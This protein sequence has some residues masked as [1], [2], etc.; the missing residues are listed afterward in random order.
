MPPPATRGGH[1]TFFKYSS[2]VLQKKYSSGHHGTP[3]DD[4][5]F[6]RTTWDSSGWLGF[7]RKTWILYITLKST[8]F[9][10]SGV[11]IIKYHQHF[12]FVQNL[13]KIICI[14][15]SWHFKSTIFMIF[16]LVLCF[17][18]FFSITYNRNV[19]LREYCTFLLLIFRIVH[20]FNE[21]L[22]R[23]YV[24]SN[25]FYF[26]KIFFLFYL[27]NLWLPIKY[28]LDLIGYS[29][30]KCFSPLTLWVFITLFSE[31]FSF[32]HSFIWIKLSENQMF[33]FFSRLVLALLQD[34]ASALHVGCW[35]TTVL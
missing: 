8:N 27:N 9:T 7:V 26:L 24:F 10:G 31:V 25:H 35:I 12:S 23:G 4:L 13:K 21:V 22:A 33:Q 16:C 5:G 2:G 18:S 14:Y 30:G 32:T 34:S 15:F 1:C 3:R 19:N 20:F 6:P 28:P 17:I 11:L 29:S